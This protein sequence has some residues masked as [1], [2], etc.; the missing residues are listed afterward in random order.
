MPFSVIGKAYTFAVKAITIESY[1][2]YLSCSMHLCCGCVIAYSLL[3]TLLMLSCTRCDATCEQIITQN[4][5]VTLAVLPGFDTDIAAYNTDIA[6]F[7]FSGK[8]VHIPYKL[9]MHQSP[10]S[11]QK[12]VRDEICLFVLH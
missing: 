2:S 10:N 7:N 12:V 9:H 5:P 6:Y 3:T 1:L 8:T 4:S 11:L